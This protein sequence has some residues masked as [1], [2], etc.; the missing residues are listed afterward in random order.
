MY[1]TPAAA[2]AAA[3]SSDSGFS[4]PVAA[5]RFA[6]TAWCDPRSRTRTVRS[7]RPASIR[8]DLRVRTPSVP[9][10]AISMRARRAS[11][12]AMHTTVIACAGRP[13]LPAAGEA[14]ASRAP[15]A[16]DRASRALPISSPVASSTSVSRTPTEPRPARA[17]S[18][19][20]PRTRRST[21]AKPSKSADPAPCPT[22]STAISGYAGAHSG[23]IARSRANPVGVASSACG[24]G[25]AGAPP[26]HD[27]M[28]D[29]RSAST[30]AGAGHG[31]VPCE[32]VTVPQPTAT[33]VHAAHPPAI[34]RSSAAAAAPTM[35][36]T[37]SRPAAS[38]RCAELASDPCTAASD[39]TRMASA[40]DASDEAASERPA[41]EHPPETHLR[42]SGTSYLPPSPTS[43]DSSSLVAAI[44]RLA[45]RSNATSSEGPPGSIDAAPRTA[46]RTREADAPMSTMA[47]TSMSPDMPAT[48]ASTTI[49]MRMQG[50]R[51]RITVCRARP[52]RAGAPLSAL[53]FP[54]GACT[55]G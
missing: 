50:G 33:G 54:A 2:A 34:P 16:E 45:V 24:G 30:T 17:S 12:P 41:D 49:A 25:P 48:C 27:R 51:R 21:F 42:R 55:P 14:H 28:P 43:A 7:E 4:R 19:A 5:L 29:P 26:G 8:A 10:S 11:A 38:C 53:S 37:V 22:A 9:V 46:S 18:A 35:S 3:T 47:D 6:R 39:S 1:G 20:S 15:S 31:V 32:N 44:P 13:F 40:S 36:A 52:R 23:R